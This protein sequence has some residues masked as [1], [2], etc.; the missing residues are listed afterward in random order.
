MGIIAF[1]QITGSFYT[2]QADGPR[3]CSIV[4]GAADP[5]VPGILHQHIGWAVDGQRVGYIHCQMARVDEFL[6]SHTAPVSQAA[7]MPGSLLHMPHRNPSS[8]T[9][10]RS[11]HTAAWLLQGWHQLPAASCIYAELVI[12]LWGFRSAPC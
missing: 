7:G 8:H 5:P 1:L 3:E 9:G 11:L 4:G 12:F 6:Q 2:H 10:S